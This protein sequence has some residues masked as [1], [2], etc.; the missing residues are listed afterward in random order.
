MPKNQHT[1]A[2]NGTI[3][4]NHVS[5]FVS[6]IEA[7]SFTAA[8]KAL[9]APKSSVSRA[10][11]KLED[12][13]GVVLLTRTTRKLAL[14]EAG[15]LYLDRAREA[16]HL[17]A[18]ARDHIIEADQEPRGIVRFTAPP[19]PTGSLLSS[20]IA[21]FCARYPSIHI[22]VV[23]SGS[24]IDLVEEGIDLALRAGKLD[25]ASLVGKRI[26]PTPMHLVASPA[27]LKEHGTPRRLADLAQHRCLLF[28]AVRGTQRF[29][30][31]RKDKAESVE[32]SGPVS[33]DELSFVLPL[34]V[35]GL[36]IALM[37]AMMTDRARRAG[38][39]VPVL[40]QYQQ[41]GAA[42]HLVHPA[43]RHLPHRVALFRDFLYDE[44]RAQFA[45]LG[46]VGAR[47]RRVERA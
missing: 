34:A 41:H 39:L 4:L 1:V 31:T 20:A 43:A 40:A 12:E 30:L 27:Y 10:V 36:G 3:D 23:F 25:D 19:D 17:L 15:R 7:G 14:T 37:P 8:A 47:G 13:L 5:V 29:T 18:E 33:V 42:L 22:D 16:L 44:L 21:R 35:A 28:R 6:V 45:G 32:V 9:G 38:S 2:Q 46:S 26:G 11:S 24:R